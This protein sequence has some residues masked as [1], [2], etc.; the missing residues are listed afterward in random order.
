MREEKK[1]TLFGHT[2]TKLFVSFELKA[3][4]RDIWI[5]PLQIFNLKDG[6][7]LLVGVIIYFR[8]T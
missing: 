2:T 3:S 5:F 7:K 1:Q 4:V 6:L 8:H